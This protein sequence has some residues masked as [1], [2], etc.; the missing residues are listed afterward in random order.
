[1]GSS[2]RYSLKARLFASLFSVYIFG[3]TA[4]NADKK[5][6]T[7]QGL[8]NLGTRGS[9]NSQIIIKLLT[10]HAKILVA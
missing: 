7:G 10:L 3:G 5:R 6:D 2:E 9:D 1:M 4:L 8:R